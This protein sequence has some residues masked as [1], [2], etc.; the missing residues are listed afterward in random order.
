MLAFPLLHCEGYCE[1]P[2]IRVFSLVCRLEN[3]QLG[4]IHCTRVLIK[5]GYLVASILFIVVLVNG[6]RPSPLS[7]IILR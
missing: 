2:L 7:S 6:K 1:I 5:M 3:F 4:S